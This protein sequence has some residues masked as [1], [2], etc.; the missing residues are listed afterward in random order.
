MIEDGERKYH[1]GLTRGDL[2]GAE[3][4][5]MPGDPGRVPKIAAKLE[6]A[7]QIGMNREYTSWSGTCANGKKILVIS[8]GMGGPSTAIAV[9]ELNM[10][11]IK[12]A[13]RV[14]TCGGMQPEVCAGDLIVVS[15]AVRQ[16]GTSREYVP[17][18][19]PAISDPDVL[20]ALRNS[21]ERLRMKYH[22][23]IVQCKDSFYGQ[24]EPERMPAGYELM[25]KWEAWK[26]SGVLASEMESA[27]LF[28]VAGIL[29][30]R[31]G[32]VMLCVWNQE[33]ELLGL[34]NDEVHDSSASIKVAVDAISNL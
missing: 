18:E 28:V 10:L 29:K 2:E 31:A 8:T 13:I 9:E 14:G 4:A 27:A 26:K 34:G 20:L 5:I 6:Q 21:A 16:E 3:Y 25:D 15:G 22:V 23:G 33:R 32:A 24:H 30:M 19:Y 12:T 1:I 17:V 7:R 11:G